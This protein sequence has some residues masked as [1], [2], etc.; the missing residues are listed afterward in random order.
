MLT[1]VPPSE[2]RL[3]KATEKPW[4]LLLLCLVWLLPGLFGRDPL[5]PDETLI[6]D[7]VK[8]MLSGGSL[9]TPMI[10]GEV[11]VV[12]PP[13]FVWVA[14]A[15]AWL[16]QPL[17]IAIHD[18]A[19]LATIAFASLTLWG[20]G[21]AG[22]EALG[23]RHG[24]SAVL[25]LIGCLGFLLPGHMLNP[26]I[27]M[28]AGW[29]LGLYALTL[30]RRLPLQS[31][32]LL[33]TAL[34]ILGLSANLVA[35]LDL[36]LLALSIAVLPAWRNPRFFS[37]L[38]IALALAVP[39]MLSW[40]SALHQSHPAA[41][42]HWL[43]VDALGW[44]GGLNHIRATHEFGYYFGLLPWYAWP[45]WPL[46]AATLWMHK[47][48]L[49]EP[50]LLM[51]LIAAA[52]VL[53]NLS[54][55]G[56]ARESYALLLLPPLALIGAFG[57]DILR[58]G[59]SAFLN[60][61]G[62]MTF[63]LLAVF[64]WVV[65]SAMHLGTPTR[66]ASRIAEIN[67]GFLSE[68]NLAKVAIALILT[69]V[70][71]LSVSRRR[72]MGRQAVTNW[73][74]GITLVWG[75]FVCFGTDFINRYNGYRDLSHSLAQAAQRDAC[76]S[77]EGLGPSQLA[78]FHYYADLSFKHSDD[79]CTFQLRQE[80]APYPEEAVDQVIWEGRRAGDAREIY[81]L[82]HIDTKSRQAARHNHK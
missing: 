41:F 66:L 25:I 37:G 40:I 39:V 16:G 18:A 28:A 46:A 81:R 27:A 36:L 30:A 47:D 42:N 32:A 19:R 43:Q 2:Q 38:V 60:W 53:L 11:Y 61:F 1:Y 17:G 59:A 45:A 73:A 72:P 51:P 78:V 9:S 8:H 12:R 35:P 64:L 75:L 13:L 31:G 65:W 14:S 58:R 52:L 26:D 49:S 77:A 20:V 21:L 82:Y 56:V 63:G 48:R 15:F 6:V 80:S 44:F 29:S 70:W 54:L 57:L 10:G 4:L 74:A 23:R 55:A 5:K 33:G 34:I 68:M 50:R 67:P 62:V 7:M 69:G 3:P 79:A 76:I 71:V 22:R 24:R